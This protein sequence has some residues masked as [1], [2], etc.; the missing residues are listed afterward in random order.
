[1]TAPQITIIVILSINLLAGANLH[2]KP[3]KDNYNFW[4]YFLNAIMITSILYWGKFF[5]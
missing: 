3:R 4:H 5:N 1:M 2:G